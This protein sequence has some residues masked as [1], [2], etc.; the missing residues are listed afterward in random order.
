MIGAAEATWTVAE[1][2][3]SDPS[4]GNLIKDIAREN[5]GMG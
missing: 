2:Q 1:M 4:S 3:T 5:C